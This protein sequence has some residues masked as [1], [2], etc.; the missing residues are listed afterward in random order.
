MQKIA[1]LLTVFNGQRWLEEQLHSILNQQNAIFDLYISDDLSVDNSFEIIKSYSK[2]FD[3]IIALPR[4]TGY[5]NAAQNFFRLIRDVDFTK[6]SLVAFSDQDDIWLPNKLH[7][8]I[9]TIN[10]EMVDG[11]SSNVT[12][13]WPEGKT[14][15]INKAQKQ[16]IYDYMFE[17]AGPGCTFVISQK[18]ALAIQEL[19]KK[20]QTELSTVALHDWFIYAFARSNNY[21]WYIDPTPTILY[22]QHATNVVGANTGIKALITRLTKLKQGW[23]LQQILLVAKELGYQE[24]EP[25]KKMVHLGIWDRFYLAIFAHQFRRRLRDQLG[26]AFFALFLAKKS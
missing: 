7:L 8:A 6:Y 17:S 24:A 3:N 12:A 15:L 10:R 4:D 5:G 19:L 2:K 16:M 25:I 11:Y 1:I 22:R 14:K 18:L 26:F 21:K 23:Y 20:K 13:F 9:E